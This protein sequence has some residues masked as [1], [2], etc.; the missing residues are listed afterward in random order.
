MLLL[1]RIFFFCAGLFL[2][3][4]VTAQITPHEAVAQMKRGINMGNT[5]EPPY[6]DGW[7]NPPAEEYYFDLYKEAGFD[8]VRV[9]VRWHYH[10]STVAPFTVNETWMNRVEEVVEWGLSRDLYIVIN[11]HHEEWIKEDYASATNRTRFD[12]IWSQIAVRFK[13]KSEKLIFEIINEPYG[14]SKAQNDDLHQRVLS[15]IRRSNPTRNVIIQGHNWGGSEEL[16]EMAIP[17]DD[18]LIGS[19][20]S[21]D[22]WPFGLEGT[23][24]F[25]DS[26]QIQA[27]D[28][29]FSDVKG[30]SDQNNIP[31]FLGEFGCN[32]SAD[33][34]SRMNHY[35][36][37]VNLSLKYGFTSCAWDDGGNFRILLRGS[38]GWDEVKDILIHS[39]PGSPTIQKLSIEQDTIIHIEWS[40]GTGDHDSIFIERRTGVEQYTRVTS[41]NPDTTSFLD[42]QPVPDRYHHYRIIAHYNTGEITHSHPQKVFLKEYIP[43]VRD[44][45]LGQP[46]PIPGTIEA[47]DFDTGGEGL[48]YHDMD[49]KNIA[50]AYRPHE[51]VDIY[52]RNG[53]GY[54]IGNALPG[55]WYEYSVDVEQ[56]GEYFIDVHL[57]AVQAGGKFLI[58][59]GETTS[60]TLEAL[61]SNSWL[62]TEKVSFSISLTGGE[63]IMRFTV[64]DL[65]LFNIDKIDFALNTTG[66]G[67]LLPDEEALTLFLD[68]GGDLI[69]T[70]QDHG[71]IE[72]LYMYSLSG[73]L[74]RSIQQ[75]DHPCRLS[76]DGMES[77]IYIIKAFSSNHVHYVKTLIK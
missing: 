22:P 35:R 3:G 25:G 74:V 77:G 42:M 37:Y 49:Q 59:I 21:Y 29:K 71:P 36:S 23:G 30:W 34:N 50:G 58:T 31:V 48:S 7:N 5:L 46:H 19:F 18:Y 8:V 6:E 38:G 13:D 12:S 75:P 2:T 16:I 54:H 24:T 52:D 70:M 32:R 15:I 45:F 61:N 1:N 9:P 76:T 67:N 72:L 10:T 64:I 39:S 11:A 68:P 56:E 14:L 43:Q 27:L 51:A 26:W 66:I 63:H 44:Y 55:E 60:D 57:A 17:V 69:I 4:T 47:E 41:L 33:Y 73:A 20:H 28:N 65:P 40:N 53:D 62:D